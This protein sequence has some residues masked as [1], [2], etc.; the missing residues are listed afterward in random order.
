MEAME[1]SLRTVH[2]QG[3][4]VRPSRMVAAFTDEASPAMAFL[5]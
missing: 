1:E 4:P 5:L 2:M 3:R